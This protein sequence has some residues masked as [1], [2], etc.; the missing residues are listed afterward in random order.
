VIERIL[1]I[2]VPVFLVVALGWAWARR[3]KPDMAWVN[4]LNMTVLAPALIFTALSGKDFDLAANRMLILAS[5]AI[6]V[7]SGLLAWPIA[8]LLRED[9]RTFVPPMMFNNC[10]NMGLPL[11]VLAYGQAGFSA[12][13][14][15]FTVSN[16]LHFTL[17]VWIIDHHARFGRLLANPMVV[18]TVLGFAFAAFHPP[19]PEWLAMALKLT[20]DAMIPL[21]LISLG[22]R[23]SDVPWSSWRVGLIGGLV[24]PLAGIAVA[25]LLGLALSLDRTQQGLLLLFGCLPPAVLN[26]MVA[27]QF[28]QEPGKVAS[29]VLIGNVLALAFVPLGLALALR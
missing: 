11:A 14:A 6:V 1:G 18:A 16:L 22:V 20:G 23:L 26:F 12:M 8:R 19:L 25:G 7:G 3:T 10:G 5:V 9:K 27:E 29:I 15:L 2:I 21:M 28:H 24:R 13:V 4:R 17:G